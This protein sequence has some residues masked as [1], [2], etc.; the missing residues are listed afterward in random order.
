MT[1]K[2]NL[3]GDIISLLDNEYVRVAEDGTVADVAGYIDTGSYALNALIS[4]SIYKGL[5]A[6]KITA[7]AGAEASGKTFFLIGIIKYFLLA[8][9]NGIV[10]LCESENSITKEI[11][12][13][14]QVDVKRVLIVPVDTVQQFKTQALKIVDNH[15]KIPEK[16]RRPLFLA[17][18]SLGMLSTTKEMFDSEAGKETKDMTRTQEIKAAFRVLTNKL[19]KAKIPMVV[20]NHVYQ[21]MGMFPTTELSGGSG[22]KYSANNIIALGKSKDKDSEGDLVGAI[23][24]C[25]NM[26]SRLTKEGTQVRVQLSFT[27]GLNRYFGLVDIAIEAGILTKGSNKIIFPDGKS[28]FEK[29]VNADAEKLFTKELL[30]KIDEA[31]R[32]QFCYGVVGDSE[33]ITEEILNGEE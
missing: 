15:L 12:V 29:K 10:I 16:E 28:Y 27:K 33:D 24:R 20:T 1:K 2:D 26:K 14:R 30:D 31:C 8:N 18:D 22:L 13:D 25:K 32:Q 19:G 23:I 9:P 4:G 21:S 7:I 17:L 3:F 6:N 5:P 11:L